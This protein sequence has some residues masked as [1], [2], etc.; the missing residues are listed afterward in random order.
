MCK[1]KLADLEDHSRRNNVVIKDIPETIQTTALKDYVV[2]LMDTFL[3]DTPQ[4]KL[5]IDRIHRLPKPAHPPDTVPQNMVAHVHFFHVKEKMD[6]LQG[7]RLITHNHMQGCLY[8]LS[9]YTMLKRKSLSRITKPLLSHQIT[10]K[11][12]PSS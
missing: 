1:A 2:Q 9:Q 10:S 8:D 3:P 12:G 11:L 4:V 6:C 7:I 5:V